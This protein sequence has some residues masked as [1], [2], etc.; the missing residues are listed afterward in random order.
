[1]ADSLK[2]AGPPAPDFPRP[3]SGAVELVGRSPAVLRVHELLRQAASRDGAVL[4]VAEP[5]TH[6][7]AVARELHRRSLR[8]DA[9]FVHVE[10][11]A[12]ETMGALLGHAPGDAIADLETI[13]A[14]CEVAAA[15][16]GTLF[17]QDVAELPA[18]AQTRLA[19]IIRDREVRMAGEPVPT[20]LR[21]IAAASP[22]IDEDVHAN[23]FRSDLYRR[24]ATVRIDLPSLRERPSDVPA[25][26]A[27]LL[28]DLCGALECT[29]R[30]LSPP[31]LSL[32]G[33]LTWPG[34]L[35]ELRQAIARVAGETTAQVLEIEHVL[36]A[37][38]LDRAMAPFVPTG[39][40]RDA[41]IRFERDYIAAVLQHHGWRIADAAQTLG[42]QRPNLYRKARQ[43]G[44]PLGPAAQ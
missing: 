31:A 20:E 37:L 7:L 13:S 33:A 3:S 1:M 17:L 39:N 12:S 28:D 36:P 6:V 16:G 15:R 41:R 11:A 42:I 18:A 32:L 8:G 24:I 27:R 4:L 9:P 29:P 34:N 40:L 19:R 10:C 38:R 14:D 23:R 25:L 5:G 2:L 22:A 35:D 30:T 21:I 26:A 43:L 44:I